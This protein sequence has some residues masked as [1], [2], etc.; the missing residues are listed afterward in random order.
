MQFK[1]FAQNRLI[2]IR[3][4]VHPDNR[5][6]C[7]TNENP[8]DIITRIKTCDISTDNLWWEG[9]HFL[10]NVVEYNNR[11]RK[12]TKIE[13]DDSLWNSCNERIAKTNSYLV[14]GEKKKNIENIIDIKNFN[15][16]KKFL[17]ITSWVLRFICN[18]KSRICGKKSDLKNYLNSGEINNSKN[19]SLQISQ[20]ELTDK[21]ENFVKI[22]GRWNRTL[23]M[24]CENFTK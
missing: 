11:L 13:I 24:S 6:C 9:P 8:A 21:F 10:K 18:V 22:K 16:L 1:T 15:T 20:E 19:W 12:Q 14:T 7:S 4:N 17:I 2:A 3:N 23:S 5:K